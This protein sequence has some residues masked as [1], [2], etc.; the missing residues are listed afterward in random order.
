MRCG[1][2]GT[3]W[4]RETATGVTPTNPRL[5]VETN[6]YRSLRRNNGSKWHPP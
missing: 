5:L 4:R 2:S 1:C 3:E 6:R